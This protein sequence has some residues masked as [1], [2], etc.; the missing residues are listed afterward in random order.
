MSSL[1]PTT[2]G[3][4]A[5]LPVQYATIPAGPPPTRFD[6]RQ[7]WVVMLHRAVLA[8]TVAGVVAL[9]VMA[10]A[11]HAPPSYQS[12][13][14]VLV[15][16]NQS[17][18]IK[19]DPNAA[20]LPADTGVVDTQVEVLK[21]RAVAERVANRLRLYLDPEFNPEVPKGVAATRYR[22]DA[23]AMDRVIERVSDQLGVRRLGLTYVIEVTFR[24]GTPA[25]AAKIANTFVEEYVAQQVQGK[26][27][28]NRQANG[29]LN[30]SLDKLR[31][32]SLN[33]D[34]R[35][36][37]Y[38]NA[39]NLMSTDGQAMAEQSVAKLSD[40]IATASADTAEK[41]ARLA[42]AQSEFKSGGDGFGAGV[43][44]E[45]IR[46]LR[47]SEADASREV[48][49]LAVTFGPRYPDLL[50]ARTKL[51]DIRREVEVE[52]NRILANLGSEVTAARQR[53]GSLRG[54]FGSARGNVAN[55]NEAQ[56][57]LI[58]LKQQADAA[59]KVYE[60]Y[61][62]RADQLAA[63]DGVQLPDARMASAAA[64]PVH[65]VAPKKSIAAV[66]A[67]MIGGIAAL[68][69]VLV[70]EFLSST[71][72][73]RGDVEQKLGAP[74][75]GVIPDP[76]RL[77]LGRR[78]K[79]SAPA[80]LIVDKPFSS[81]AEAFRNV[82]ANLQYWGD[83]KNPPRVIAVTSALPREG[84]STTALGLTRALATSGARV[85][86]IDC[87]FRRSALN[88]MIG[89]PQ[90]G[91]AD[92]LD[93]KAKMSDVIIKD[94]RTSALILP[95]GRSPGAKEMMSTAVFEEGLAALRERFDHIVIDTPPVLAVADARLIAAKADVALMVSEW[96]KTPSRAAAAA[97]ELL[98]AA[99]VNLAGV[100]LNKVDVRLHAQYGYGDTP[101]A[102]KAVQ[103]YHAG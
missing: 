9:A 90:R 58:A 16:P 10:I 84:K 32:D 65:P 51:A 82:R 68:A 26:I 76:A 60:A 46:D 85:I 56:V 94:P 50:K 12:T 103:A 41:S 8:V 53:E 45:T 79:G 88:N 67:V 75:A 100:A 21:T 81:Y 7:I 6:P 11:L 74:F 39:H 77:R 101:Y 61:L 20:A 89:N 78:R 4:L 59:R 66:A 95:W 64:P 25:K 29:W 30:A 102:Y 28:A 48:A 18:V 80:D 96:N 72:R 62:N 93:G 3:A 99:G 15:E 70:A 23:H 36:Q 87:D 98:R 24:A 17:K 49:E 35:M 86:L 83:G 57:Q 55:S 54:S 5:H 52:T 31:Q 19:D 27:N 97:V 42:A 34:F 44:N 47:K 43:G 37:E 38:I 40:E 22:P 92:V 2:Q 13:A 91:L 63:Q 73:T 69:A 1:A 14:T 71:M 33:A